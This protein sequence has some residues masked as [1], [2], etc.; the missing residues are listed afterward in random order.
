[1]D[2][3]AKTTET[4]LPPRSVDDTCYVLDLSNWARA[5]SRM[6]K[7]ELSHDGERIEVIGGVVGR[8]VNFVRAVDPAWFVVC[9]DAPDVEP[10]R[11]EWWSGYKAGREA[12]TPEY[13]RQLNTLV[14]LFRMHRIQVHVGC[15]YEADD[16]IASVVRRMSAVGVRSVIVS[17]DQDLWQLVGPRVLAFEWDAAEERRR[18]IGETEVMARYHG[19]PPTKLVDLLALAGDGDEAPG[20]EGIGDML[21]AKLV[22]HFGSLE[23]VLRRGP[24]TPLPGVGPKK[25]A[26]IASGRDQALLS[27]R[28]VTLMDAPIELDLATARFGWDRADAE[29]IADLYVDLGLRRYAD[30]R[31]YPKRP[32]P[33]WALEALAKVQGRR[34]ESSANAQKSHPVAEPT[35]TKRANDDP[36]R[37]P[38][39]QLSLF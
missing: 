5:I 9:A 24:H 21:A 13:V 18:V 2:D 28:L 14:E 8:F 23:E 27:R 26:S 36:V 11:R 32:V 31:E 7:P 3:L 39:E 6:A 4:R 17:R 19:T 10:K 1:M 30:V 37:M 22:A 33:G 34:V 15:G 25:R 38:T 35:S 20:V 16:Y 12:K 29:A